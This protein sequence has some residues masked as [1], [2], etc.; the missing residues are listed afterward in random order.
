MFIDRCFQLAYKLAYRLIHIYWFICRPSRRSALVAIW[1]DDRI[2]LVKPSYMP[3]Y[4]LP[5]GGVKKGEEPVAA[6]VRELEEEI[7]LHL[8]AD[9]LK[10]VF[11]HT[12]NKSGMTDTVIIFETHLTEP[13]QITID[14]R[15]IIRADFVTV[16]EAL[17][18]DLLPHVEQYLRNRN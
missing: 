10:L 12:C 2:L 18:R 4:S 16:N 14:N 15:E 17:S 6:A 1:H 8:S 11:E 3:V 9:A 5:G 13:P 7:D